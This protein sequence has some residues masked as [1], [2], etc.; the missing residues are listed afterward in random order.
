MQP[1]TPPRIQKPSKSSALHT[2]KTPFGKKLDKIIQSPPST[3]NQEHLSIGNNP[4]TPGPTPRHS[5]R[6]KKELGDAINF[7]LRGSS[8]SNTNN[9]SLGI[10]R[11]LFPPTP[12]TIGSGRS[13]VNHSLISPI[14]KIELED[15]EPT[16]TMTT[17]RKLKFDIDLEQ[18]ESEEEEEQ[19]GSGLTPG[20]QLITEKL[21]KEWNNE[22]PSNGF[23]SDDE[24]FISRKPLI[25]PFLTKNNNNKSGSVINKNLPKQTEI[26]LINKKGE[27]IKRTLTEDES[28]YKPKNL[29]NDLLKEKTK[30]DVYN[31]DNDDI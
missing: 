12:S 16:N 28:N 31:D 20:G 29:F 25:N 11:S 14:R 22:I 13:K 30:I 19:N 4:L 21:V 27:K 15:H 3:S 9:S 6:K 24:E 7:N 26:T 10:Q 23:D 5:S 2:P 8:S 17:K 18:D 1:L